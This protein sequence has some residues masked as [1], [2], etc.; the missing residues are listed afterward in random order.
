[1]KAICGL[2]VL[3]MMLGFSS[4]VRAQNSMQ[5]LAPGIGWAQRTDRIYWTEDNGISW[6]DITPAISNDRQISDIFFLDSRRGWLLASGSSSDSDNPQFV[7]MSTSDSGANWTTTKVSV[8]PSDLT[9]GWPLTGR[10]R[11]TFADSANGWLDLDSSRNTAFASGYLYVTSDGGVTWRYMGGGGAYNDP[12]ELAS[13]KDGWM[14]SNA[15]E[16]LWVTHDG[17]KSWQQIR[18]VAPAA[19]APAN[20]SA[21]YG[22]PVFAADNKR[23]LIQVTF[24]G[25]T[26][27]DIKSAVV[28]F[29]T[30]DGG[31]TWK[32]DRA[33]AKLFGAGQD[34]LSSAIAGS[35]WI[36]AS[37]LDHAPTLV[38]VPG[39]TTIDANNS[40]AALKSQADPGTGRPRYRWVHRL[41]FVSPMQGWVIVGDGELSSTT[42]GGATWADITPVPMPH[43][44]APHGN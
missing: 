4:G 38:S 44:I 28:L 5:L 40:F 25:G 17:A 33:I 14:V 13:P 30:Q 1:M 41:S 9:P 26:G 6:R 31:R 34:Q 27:L 23:G 7:L 16:E 42:D 24:S 3:A 43:V 22:L 11:I 21:T 18:L 37:A 20:R 12:M 36:V 32:P 15:G 10:G 2:L 8:S 35:A 29:A 39:G 19:V